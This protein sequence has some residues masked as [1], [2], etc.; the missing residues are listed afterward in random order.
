MDYFYRSIYIFTT[1]SLEL[2]KNN[3]NIS[4]SIIWDMKKEV[5]KIAMDIEIFSQVIVVRPKQHT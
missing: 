2:C 4:L 3:H 5:Q 1:E